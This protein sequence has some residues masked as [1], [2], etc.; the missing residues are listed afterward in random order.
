[1]NDKYMEVAEE[2]MEED[3]DYVLEN[4]NYFREQLMNLQQQAIVALRKGDRNE[5][6]RI[7]KDVLK[8]KQQL[9]KIDKEVK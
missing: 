3:Y 7:A 1:M 2:V 9:I 4:C 8:I 5:L 6:S